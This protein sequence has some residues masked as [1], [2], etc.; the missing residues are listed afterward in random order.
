M[1]WLA[2]GKEQAVNSTELVTSIGLP[3]SKLRKIR[4]AVRV[5]LIKT[6]VTHCIL[7]S[8]DYSKGN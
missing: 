8:K 3:S 7:S 2:A 6:E 5:Q 1:G 4:V